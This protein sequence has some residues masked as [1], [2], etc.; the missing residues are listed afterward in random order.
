MGKESF[1]RNVGLPATAKKPKRKNPKAGDDIRQATVE[2]VVPDNPVA[3]AGTTEKELSTALSNR[4][5]KLE[6]EVKLDGDVLDKVIDVMRNGKEE[7]QAQLKAT[8]EA[9]EAANKK[10]ST[11]EE[12]LSAFEEATGSIIDGLQKKVEE[13][14]GW[15]A[16]QEEAAEVEEA[17]DEDDRCPECRA[18]VGFKNLPVQKEYGNEVDINKYLFG[19]GKD[20][21]SLNVIG[22][23]RQCPE[24]GHKEPAAEEADIKAVEVPANPVKSIYA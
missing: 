4:V 20:E 23:F 19:K 22:L 17:V 7:N 11:L 15:K 13:L 16:N 18:N 21:D 8:T 24:C 12:S 14:V 10:A 6:N 2:E 5:A 9:L 1:L 3:K